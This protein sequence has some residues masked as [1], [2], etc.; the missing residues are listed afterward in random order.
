ML[1]ILFSRYSLIQLFFFLPEIKKATRIYFQPILRS[2]DFVPKKYSLFLIKLIKFINPNCI[3]GNYEKDKFIEQEWQSNSFCIDTLKSQENEINKGFNARFLK[4]LFRSQE[5]TKFIQSS[6]TFLP[7][8]H[9]FL[10]IS[11]RISQNKNTL[12]IP[13]W[14]ISRGMSRKISKS[15]LYFLR[16]CYSLDN[17]IS[18]FLISLITLV[19]PFLYL[20]LLTKRGFSFYIKK[21]KEYLLLM[22]VVWGFSASKGV[23]QGGVLKA[24]DDSYLYGKKF[25]PGTIIHTFGKWKFNSDVESRYKEV[26]NY[27]K[28]EYANINRYV[29]TPKFIWDVVKTQVLVIYAFLYTFRFFK[30]SRREVFLTKYT[31]KALKTYLDQLLQIE[32]INYKAE[33]VRDDYNPLHII[34]F[35]ANH[36]KGIKSI[37]IQHTGSPYEAPQLA[38]VKFDTYAVFGE[39]YLKM[40][41]S[42]WFD[43]RLAKTGRENLDYVYNIFNNHNKKKD[44]LIK[45]QKIYGV[46]KKVVLILIPSMSVSMRTSALKEFSDGLNKLSQVNQDF[47]IVIRP[48][49]MSH[50]RMNKYIRKIAKLVEKDSRFIIEIENFTTQELF[51]VSDIIITSNASFGINESVPLGKEVYTFDFMG[52][53][54]LYFEKYDRNFV[55][56]TASQLFDVITQISKN[57]KKCDYNLL[58]KDLNFHFDGKNCTRIRNAILNE[59]RLS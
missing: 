36:R 18:F 47:L 49:E 9:A 15:R 41:A 58:V 27:R 44:L 2:K 21:T 38:F 3:V 35:I 16:L 37:G 8:E 19:F 39:M 28:Y 23:L 40:F 17:T 26:M 12:C 52:T 42:S 31:L 20:I 45:F 13:S 24:R 5:I 7:P 48:R 1:N 6:L 4:I 10:M 11:E 25:T 50:M 22:P 29:I 46:K 32:N 57:K 51:F 56:E 30:F 54:K 55:L 33:L 34:N 43:I 14:E 59:L 53:G